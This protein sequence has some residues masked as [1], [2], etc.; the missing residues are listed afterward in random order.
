VKLPYEDEGRAHVQADLARELSQMGSLLSLALVVLPQAGFTPASG[1][2]MSQSTFDVVAGLYAKACKTFRA[3]MITAEAGL[4]EDTHILARALFETMLAICWILKESSLIRTQMYLAHLSMRDRK[5]FRYMRTKPDLKPYISDAA[6]AEVEKQVAEW[7]EELTAEQM[8][9]L[10]DRYSGKNIEQT[11]QEMG[12]GVT[13]DVY[14]RYACGFNHVSDLL[15]HVAYT[16]QGKL[17]L[18]LAPEPS[19]E[20]RKA[21]AMSHAFLRQ[22]IATINDSWGLGKDAEIDATVASLGVA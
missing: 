13:Y 7:E 17:M 6:L 15:S 16:E 1:K 2:E 18:K 21:M 12:L 5:N 14:Y 10:D 9:G 8:K 20:L 19:D 4:A 22:T 11:A 3:I